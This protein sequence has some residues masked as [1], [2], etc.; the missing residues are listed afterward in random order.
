M[1]LKNTQSGR[2]GHSSRK[3]HIEFKNVKMDNIVL[4]DGRYYKLERSENEKR[5]TWDEV[6]HYARE[7][8]RL[9]EKEMFNLKLKNQEVY[10]CKL[11]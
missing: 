11:S 4:S 9:S 5:S 2:F 8:E 1:I 3:I 7:I 6:V 10:K